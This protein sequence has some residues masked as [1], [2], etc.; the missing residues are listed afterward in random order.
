VHNDNAYPFVCTVS[1]ALSNCEV[2]MYKCRLWKRWVLGSIYKFLLFYLNLW[3]PYIA[4]TKTDALLC[5]NKES[6][7]TVLEKIIITER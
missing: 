5:F 7:V 2:Y 1:T 6:N 4:V 3:A